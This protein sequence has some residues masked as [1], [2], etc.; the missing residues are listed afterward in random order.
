M[1]LNRN[2]YR[3]LAVQE[4][5]YFDSDTVSVDREKVGESGD[6]WKV[7]SVHKL[8][9]EENQ[10]SHNVYFDLLDEH[11]RYI[12]APQ[13]LIGYT[14][15]G[16]NIAIEPANPIR[17]DKRGNEPKANLPIFRGQHVTAWVEDNIPSER[18]AGL[19]TDLPDEKEGNNTGHFSWYVI[20]QRVREGVIPKPP[21]TAV[22]DPDAYPPSTD[23][24]LHDRQNATAAVNRALGMIGE[25]Q[26]LLFQAQADLSR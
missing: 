21:A 5:G 24:D 20:W 17:M 12:E 4:G 14:W 1:N 25:L 22:P 18:V 16:R 15:N 9:A 2:T 13:S 7:V 3:E 19:T 6:Y 10:R 26:Q 23:P 8:T 11:G